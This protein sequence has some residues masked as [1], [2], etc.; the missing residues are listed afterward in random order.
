MHYSINYLVHEENQTS[1]FVDGVVND[2]PLNAVDVLKIT[3]DM[4]ASYDSETNY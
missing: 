2:Y 3:I 1:E 4:M